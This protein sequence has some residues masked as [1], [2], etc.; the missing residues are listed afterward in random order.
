MDFLFNHVVKNFLFVSLLHNSKRLRTLLF[1]CGLLISWNRWCCLSNDLYEGTRSLLDLIVEFLALS[2]FLLFQ[3]V[4]SLVSELRIFDLCKYCY[5]TFLGLMEMI[6][7]TRILWCR[8]IKYI[9]WRLKIILFNLNDV[10]DICL[11]L[12]Q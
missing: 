7:P 6:L 5:V 2:V 10:F 9:L 11:A 3:K 8:K 12:H 1:W 4:H